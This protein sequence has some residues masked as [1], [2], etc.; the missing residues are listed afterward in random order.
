MDNREKG[1]QQDPMQK[2]D[3]NMPKKPPLD[4]AGGVVTAAFGV[5]F[6]TGTAAGLA[7][8]VLAEGGGR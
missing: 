5:P 7:G 1:G 4:A 3:P 2:Q 6:A 8:A